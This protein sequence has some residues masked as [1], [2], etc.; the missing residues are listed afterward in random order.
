MR[1]LAIVLISMM[2]LY[3][4]VVS[5]QA[6]F[7][8]SVVV[9]EDRSTE[10]LRQGLR[11]ALVKVLSKASGVAEELI[12]QRSSLAQDLAYGDKLAAQFAYHSK[13]VCEEAVCQQQLHL[14]A[15]FPE[16][17]VVSLLQKGG[18]TFWAPERPKLKL[19]AL[20][21]QGTSTAWLA[22]R[23]Y[24]VMQDV[25]TDAVLHWGFAIELEQLSAD[26]SRLWYADDALLAQDESSSLLVVR[27]RQVDD[28][29]S[30]SASVPALEKTQFLQADSLA[31]WLQLALDWAAEQLSLEHAV[32]LL[33]TDSELVLRFSQVNSYQQYEAILA[34]VEAL[35]I[36]QHTYVLGINQQALRLAVSYTTHLEQLQQQ[37]L[38]DKRIQLNNNAIES[39]YQLDLEWLGQE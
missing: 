32:Q 24:E 2:L 11:E 23:E 29:V 31:Q 33:S 7:Y 37:L 39:N 14:K 36:V 26:P 30:G 38:Q 9:V 25:Q 5:A 27:V 17:K 8:A 12:K 4:P 16:N 19:I 21:K 22:E 6:D 18:L 1:S 13:T 28:E 35:D 10:A 20:T 34:A 3:T 15:S